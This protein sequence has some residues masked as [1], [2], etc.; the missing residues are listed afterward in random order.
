MSFFFPRRR[1]R[2]NGH[3]GHQTLNCTL[4]LPSINIYM[5][6]FSPGRKT[7][8]RHTSLWMST[9]RPSSEQLTKKG[10]FFYQDLATTCSEDA[11]G[12]Q[13]PSSYTA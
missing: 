13:G 8:G 7:D 9:P 5:S 2:E 12:Q 10:F 1:T 3:R 6:W 4:S 11:E